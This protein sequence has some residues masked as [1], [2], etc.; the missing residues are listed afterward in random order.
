MPL[1]FAGLGNPGAKYAANRHNVGFMAVDAIARRHSF[2]PWSKK[3]QGLIAEGTL[4][5]EKIILIKPQTFMNLSGQSVGEALR[6][7]KLGPG[8]LTVFYDEI[9]LAEGKLRI[10]TGGG[11]GGHNGIRSIDGHVGNAYRRVRIGVGHPGVKEMVQH[12]VLGDFGKTDRDWLDPLLDAVADNAA[13]IV[14]GDE[15][16]FMNKAA[17]AV[18]GKAGVEPEKPAPKQQS[19]IRQARPQQAPAKLPESGPMAAMLKKLFGNKD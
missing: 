3:F 12:H 14:K 17:L 8:A 4:G 5:G 6:F 1:V 9:D 15:S 18:Q 13:M 10:K 7:Y 19:H 2:S 11:A 16:G